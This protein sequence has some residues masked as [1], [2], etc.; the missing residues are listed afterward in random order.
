M[1]V[2][3]LLLLLIIFLFSGCQSN[4]VKETSND[5]FYREQTLTKEQVLATD[6]GYYRNQ[7]MML[8]G[9]Q[10]GNYLLV[11]DLIKQGLFNPNISINCME[12]IN[13]STE[14]FTGLDKRAAQNFKDYIAK[15][16][17]VCEARTEL[18]PF[19]Q[20]QN[21]L[22]SAR[23]LVF[24]IVN[25][26]VEM[27]KAVLNSKDKLKLD[28]SVAT[29][30]FSRPVVRYG[31][32]RKVRVGYDFFAARYGNLTVNQKIY[33]LYYKT[34]NGEYSYKVAP[35]LFDSFFIDKLN[36]VIQNPNIDVLKFWLKKGIK[37]A[38]I[39]VT[40]ISSA[41]SKT[42][43][44]MGEGF[45]GVRKLIDRQDTARLALLIEHLEEVKKVMPEMRD[46]AQKK[47]L[48]KTVRYLSKYSSK[49][50]IGLA[51]NNYRDNLDAVLKTLKANDLEGF[52]SYSQKV[53]HEYK[54]E[55]QYSSKGRRLNSTVEKLANYCL[56]SGKDQMQ[57]ET[58]FAMLKQPYVKNTL[59]SIKSNSLKLSSIVSFGNIKMIHE[60]QKLGFN[61]KGKRL[62]SRIISDAD[63]A[64]IKYM[65]SIGGV[66]SQKYYKDLTG[67]MCPN[68]SMSCVD[69]HMLYSVIHNSKKIVASKRIS[70][71]INSYEF[72]TLMQDYKFSQ[73]LKVLYAENNEEKIL[74]YLVN[75]PGARHL[76][77][78]ESLKAKLYVRLTELIGPSSFNIKAIIK[79]L[80]SQ[81]EQQVLSQIQKSNFKYLTEFNK[82]QRALLFSWGLSNNLIN[83]LSLH[84]RKVLLEEEMAR[85]IAEVEQER[86]DQ[87]RREREAREEAEQREI[88]S[89]EAAERDLAN[90][91]MWQGLSKSI[92]AYKNQ[93]LSALNDS[94][95]QISENASYSANIHNNSQR[96]IDSIREE[97]KNKL[98]RLNQDSNKD[99][100]LSQK[101]VTRY[102]IGGTNKR[103]GPLIK[104]VG[105]YTYEVCFTGG[106]SKGKC[107]LRKE[108]IYT[109]EMEEYLAQVR[110][111]S[112]SDGTQCDSFRRL[113]SARKASIEKSW[114]IDGDYIKNFI[115]QRY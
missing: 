45:L 57:Q 44:F 71:F 1:K 49:K 30:A 34:I 82:K 28:K 5:G 105:E 101:L 112:C 106:I 24:A 72:I 93:S 111:S 39:P 31:M 99:A 115:F 40:N 55:S 38:Q 109:Q 19:D 62:N 27:I 59:N 56:L 81:S 13:L 102:V 61:F 26:D 16:F 52:L 36:T 21:S 15:R 76:V 9:V 87:I 35:S 47:G 63:E 92:E 89:R 83:E 58:C 2:F 114:G 108:Y 85:K 25:N 53:V 14:I 104:L 42:S 33:D 73:E 95:E 110:D 96:E 94:Y 69:D 80:N 98:K 66:I 11:N 86:K 113:V 3:P 51:E 12:R 78:D 18:F 17:K 6:A 91:Q 10:G 67:S 37:I 22:S 100:Q 7:L 65:V 8:R 103:Q 88:E 64:Y 70:S 107:S 48:Y 74:M 4:E 60:L 54:D 90:Q 46:Y 29:F 97:Y 43:L 79:A 84:T 41:D 32:T 23:V 50:E 75:N 20:E 68:D 77:S